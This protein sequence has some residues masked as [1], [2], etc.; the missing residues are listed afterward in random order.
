MKPKRKYKRGY[1][2]TLFIA[3]DENTANLWQVFSEVA[4]PLISVRIDGNRTEAKALYNFHES[5][6][7][8]LRPTLKEGVRSII[9]ASRPRTT[10][11]QEFTAHIN[12]HHVWLRQGTNKIAVAEVTGSA[13]T[14]S[15]VAQLAN[16]SAFRKLV[17]EITSEETDTLLNLLEKRINISCRE[18]TVLFSIKEA[19]DVILHS[20]KTSTCKAEY[21]VLTDTYLAGNRQKNRLQR[22]LQIAANKGVKTRVVESETPAGQRITQLGGFVCITKNN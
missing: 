17:R 22:L 6:I 16:S 11:T 18:N 15:Q 10:Y 9:V 7:N 14:P 5:I 13:A 4:K 20:P 8:A 1:P 12:K 2:V 3:L 19:E 21:V